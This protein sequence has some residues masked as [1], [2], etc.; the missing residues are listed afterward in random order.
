MLEFFF[1][2]F[3]CV[4][5]GPKYHVLAHTTLTLSHVQDSFRTH[6][7]TITGNGEQLPKHPSQLIIIFMILFSHFLLV[8]PKVLIS[9]DRPII[10]FTATFP[11]I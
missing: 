9:R 6:D 5:R 7:L 2:C 1:L 11:D 3:M 10:G 8:A 4:Y